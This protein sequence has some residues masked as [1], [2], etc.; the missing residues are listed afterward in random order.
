MDSGFKFSQLEMS[1]SNHFSAILRCHKLAIEVILALMI[2][3]FRFSPSNKDVTWKMF[4]VAS[5]TVSDA[6]DDTSRQ[7]PLLIERVN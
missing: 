7:L 3:S 5:P 4:G 1:K 6:S 2:E